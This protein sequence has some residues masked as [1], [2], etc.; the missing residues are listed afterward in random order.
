MAAMAGQ[1]PS[2]AVQEHRIK[3]DATPTV[4]YESAESA[5]EAVLTAARSAA[6]LLAADAGKLAS[7]RAQHAK[8]QTRAEAAEAR[9]AAAEAQYQQ[10]KDLL[11]ESERVCA[12]SKDRADEL[13]AE[14]AE[15]RGRCQELEEALNAAAKAEE[16]HRATLAEL[17]AAQ[18]R[19]VAAGVGWNQSNESDAIAFS[20]AGGQERWGSHEYWS[21]KAAQTRGLA[22]ATSMFAAMDSTRLQLKR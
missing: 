12:A 20:C 15:S 16:Y 8:T 2:Q 9:A 11:A 10:Q 1:S 19:L 21:G 4:Q 3:I 6:S 14:L 22:A 7:E 13:A 17:E 5:V 18:R